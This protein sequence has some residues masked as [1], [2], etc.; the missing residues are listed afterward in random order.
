MRFAEPSEAKSTF[1]KLRNRSFLHNFP[2]INPNRIVPKSWPIIR[3]FLKE[4]P[5]FN[6]LSRN[7]QLKVLL[8]GIRYKRTA[9]L[10]MKTKVN[11][12]LSE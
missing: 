7:Q 6:H 5:R 4:E 8:L 2:L 3:A 9:I 1:L 12:M 10:S 11:E